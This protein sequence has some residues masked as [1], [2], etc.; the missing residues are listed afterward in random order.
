MSDSTQDPDEQTAIESRGDDTWHVHL[1]NRV[2]LKIAGRVQKTDFDSVDEYVA[3]VM[4][5]V[6]RELDEQDDDADNHVEY[7]DGEKSEELHDRL[8]SLGYL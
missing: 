7:S 8:E 2:G 6:L 1:P 5:S 4:E 3:F